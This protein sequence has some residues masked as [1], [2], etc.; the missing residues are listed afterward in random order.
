MQVSQWNEVENASDFSDFSD[1]FKKGKTSCHPKA[2]REEAL[3]PQVP[4]ADE[5]EVPQGGFRVLRPGLPQS[6]E[7]RVSTYS[8]SS[9]MKV[10]RIS[11]KISGNLPHKLETQLW[12]PHNGHFWRS[13]LNDLV[14]DWKISKQ[15]C[16]MNQTKVPF[17]AAHPYACHLLQ[18][19]ITQVLKLK[20]GL[21]TAHTNQPQR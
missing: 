3:L 21:L 7:Q 13:L 6:W 8:Q 17:K 16:S 15:T 9:I 14:V 5:R 18:W 1:F 19:P 11:R 4:E 10:V 12:V 2:F 20:T